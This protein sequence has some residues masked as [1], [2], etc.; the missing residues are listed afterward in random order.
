MAFLFCFVDGDFAEQAV[1]GRRGTGNLR[2]MTMD[3]DDP[4]EIASS[5][6]LLVLEIDGKCA[7][8]GS[9]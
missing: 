4:D 5:S 9:K 6:L 7:K 8:R 3:N 1:S 2:M